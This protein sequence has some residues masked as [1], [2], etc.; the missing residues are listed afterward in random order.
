[1]D[2]G[3]LLSGLNIDPVLTDS[4]GQPSQPIV[5]RESRAVDGALTSSDGTGDSSGVGAWVYILASVGGACCLALLAF[6][7]VLAKKK[8]DD[9]DHNSEVWHKNDAASN[10]SSIA[11]VAVPIAEPDT[12]LSLPEGEATT[13]DGD[14]VLPEGEVTAADGDAAPTQV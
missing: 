10:A 5:V 1:M 2:I 4:R 6:L 14:A 13:A 8:S 12:Q 9:E 11:E 3:A 7:V